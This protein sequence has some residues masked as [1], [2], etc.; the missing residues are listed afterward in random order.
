V[1]G[2][3]SAVEVSVEL[4]RVARVT[5]ATRRPIRWLPQRWLGQDIHFWL[6][7][8]G[9]D[10]RH[11]VGA[12]SFPVYATPA[13]RAAL[14]SGKPDCRTLFRAFTPHG[15]IWSDG[16][17]EAVDA[18]I[19]ATGY[20]P[21]LAYLAGTGALDDRG[22]VSQANGASATVEG[23]FYVGL[24]KQRTSAS[25]TIRGAGAD[26]RLVAAQISRRVTPQ[27]PPPQLA[28]ALHR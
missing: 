22:R 12:H 21:H 13:S 17:T 8:F 3:N 23:L 19:F 2:G 20:R 14:R 25:T 27:P 24:I 7:T 26:A 15:V 9:F 4:A 5:L 18:V 1:G 10:E 11:W 16:T 28:I 6:H